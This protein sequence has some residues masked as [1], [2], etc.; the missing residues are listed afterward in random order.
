MRIE[1]LDEIDERIFVGESQ[2]EYVVR[3]ECCKQ[4]ICHSCMY[5]HM[6]SPLYKKKNRCAFCNQVG[7]HGVTANIPFQV[8]DYLRKYAIPVVM[9]TAG[10]IALFFLAAISAC[11]PHVFL[12]RGVAAMVG[13]FV[14]FLMFISQLCNPT[15]TFFFANSV[16]DMDIED[17]SR[18]NFYVAHEL[19]YAT[20][21]YHGPTWMPRVVIADPLQRPPH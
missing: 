10:M 3:L 11:P 9:I 17:A 8:H 6:N 21:M 4:I 20:D 14:W 12:C 13:L 19:H 5:N 16:T 18:H 1:L 7:K 15:I 2:Y